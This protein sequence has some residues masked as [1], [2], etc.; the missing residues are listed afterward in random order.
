[1][2][3]IIVAYDK[4]FG[5]GADNDLLWKN[6]LPSDMKH[7]KSVTTGG[8]VIMGRN[9][10]ISIG[11]PLPNRRNI[12][13]SHRSEFIRGVE[14]VNSLEAAYDLVAPDM[15]VFIIGGGQIYNLAF[16]TVDRI[17]ATEVDAT[18]KNATIFFPEIDKSVWREVGREHH[19]AGGGDKYSFDF[20]EYA[21]IK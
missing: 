1:M 8:A 3:T 6:E 4:K 16:D 18:F 11:R 13:I 15:D 19:N 20:V 2:K 9:T 14:V 7:F 17:L 10:Y 21:R 5:I 12:V